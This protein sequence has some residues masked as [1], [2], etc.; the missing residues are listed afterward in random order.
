MVVCSSTLL[1]TEKYSAMKCSGIEHT[2][3]VARWWG[4]LVVVVVIIVLVAWC[5]SGCVCS[6]CSGGVV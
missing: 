1:S 3:S 4:G 2:A 5:D 6:S